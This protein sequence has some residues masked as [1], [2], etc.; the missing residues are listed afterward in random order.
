MCSSDLSKT[1][2]EAVVPISK[3]CR[4][5]LVKCKARRVVGDAHVLVTG[6]GKP[7]SVASVVRYFATAKRLSG[8]TR[9]FRYHDLRHTMASRLASR[10][11]SLQIIA[12]ALGHTSARMS[13][14]Y[15]RPDENALTTIRVALDA[16]RSG[17]SG[18]HSRQT[19]G[20]DRRPVHR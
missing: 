10:G 18:G 7:Y 19:L 12:K 5:A 11:V 17:H 13:E 8:I 9:R 6:E 2:A 16:D 3:A 15:A 1:K 20:G 4:A 14:R